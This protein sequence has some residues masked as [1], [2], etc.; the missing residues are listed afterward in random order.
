MSCLKWLHISDFHRGLKEQDRL[1][2]S[3]KEA[4][5][6]DLANLRDD[7]GPWDVV[8][9]TGDLV[10]QGTKEEFDHLTEDLEKLWKHLGTFGPPPLLLTVPGN[11]DLARPK[12]MTSTV[13]LLSEWSTQPEILNELVGSEDNE[14]LGLVREVFVNY[15]AWSDSW[16]KNHPSPPGLEVVDRVEGLL[17]GEFTLTLRKAGIDVGVV[18]LNTAFTQLKAGEYNGKLALDPRQLFKMCPDPPEWLRKCDSTLLLTHHPVEWLHPLSLDEYRSNVNPSGRFS[19]HMCGH[20][21]VGETSSISRG[22]SPARHTWH[23][24][25]LF[26]IEHTE[27]GLSRKHGYAA[28]ELR[29]Q[30]GTCTFRHWPRIAAKRPD[31]AWGLGADITYHLIK[32]RF[33]QFDAQSFRVPLETTADGTSNPAKA[34]KGRAPAKPA[35]PHANIPDA[36]EALDRYLECRDAVSAAI[37]EIAKLADDLDAQHLASENRRNRSQVD[38]GPVIALV[39]NFSSGKT[40]FVNALIGRRL[41]PVTSKPTTAAVTRIKNGFLPKV[42][43]VL[44]TPDALRRDKDFALQRLEGLEPDAD[45]DHKRDLATV[46]NLDE[47][48]PANCKEK[49][50]GYRLNTQQDLEPFK[51]FL[52]AGDDCLAHYAE[53]VDLEY[54]FEKTV[55]PHGVT[56]LDTP[57][58]DSPFPSHARATNSALHEADAVLFFTIAKRAFGANERTVIREIARIEH[59]EAEGNL[60]RHERF[61]FVV[62]AIDDEEDEQRENIVSSGKSALLN[63]KI[64]SPRVFPLSSRLALAG[65]LEIDGFELTQQ[66]QKTLKDECK[67]ASDA[68]ARSGMEAVLAELWGMLSG[69]LGQHTLERA[70]VRSQRNLTQMEQIISERRVAAGMK[71]ADVKVQVSHFLEALRRNETQLNRLKKTIDQDIKSRLEPLR[72]ASSLVESLRS[73]L[74]P[75]MSLV[76]QLLAWIS[77]EK[78]KQNPAALLEFVKVWSEGRYQAIEREAAAIALDVGKLVSEALR[79]LDESRQQ[80]FDLPDLEFAPISLDKYFDMVTDRNRTVE[81]AK[82]G[83]VMGGTAV[84]IT[85]VVLGAGAPAIAFATLVGAAATA[86]VSHDLASD[87]YQKSLVSTFNRLRSQL[88]ATQ[89]EVEK[90]LTQATNSIQSQISEWATRAIDGYLQDLRSQLRELEDVAWEA[91]RNFQ[92][93]EE[94]LQQYQD[95][96]DSASKRLEDAAQ[97][98]KALLAATERDDSST[99]G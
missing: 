47:K 18:G 66:E 53:R 24:P 19:I 21:H 31:G 51:R 98:V 91:E 55:F 58:I 95:Q 50:R 23:A 75:E 20:Q 41:L 74:P 43:V 94:R 49:L 26:G 13:R 10:Q 1:W 88:K 40:T 37:S 3:I 46:A 79:N 39:G 68:W 38:R 76:D 85:T 35:L 29:L 92:A 32:D 60:E 97:C 90:E 56:L 33:F 42:A 52:A 63:Q 87:A 61:L 80:L 77:T 73:R 65:R 16:Q 22:G 64:A 44:K 4:F 69:R 14:Y 89:G 8:F 9:F 17:P 45:A 25:S 72:E 6:S 84:L 67:S 34:L 36:P 7:A 70:I 5:F 2:P 15:S 28:G 62:N 99:P 48:Y 83:A 96:L 78:V 12:K 86:W 11:H 27:D 71:P 54:N 59:F 82:N 93:V 30:E 81:W 57:G